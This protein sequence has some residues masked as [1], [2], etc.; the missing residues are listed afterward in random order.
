MTPIERI[1]ANDLGNAHLNVVAFL[2]KLDDRNDMQTVSD[3]ERNEVEL[4]R[5]EQKS[6]LADPLGSIGVK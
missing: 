1:K 5:Q 6:R 3:A 2:L 4:A